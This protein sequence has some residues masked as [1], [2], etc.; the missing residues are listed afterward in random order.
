CQCWTQGDG[1]DSSP[2]ASAAGPVSLAQRVLDPVR[3][4]LERLGR[5]AFLGPLPSRAWLGR[6]TLKLMIQTRQAVQ[7]NVRRSDQRIVQRGQIAIEVHLAVEL[8]TERQYAATYAG[9]RRRRL[10]RR[11]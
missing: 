10:W 5:E 8:A 4:E 7:Y 6:G 9:E 3:D 2:A 11:S 1:S